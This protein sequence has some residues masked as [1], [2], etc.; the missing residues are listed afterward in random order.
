[1]LRP[2]SN[3][4]WCI[5]AQSTTNT[6][7]MDYHEFRFLSWKTATFKSA[8]FLY[9]ILTSLEHCLNSIIA[10]YFLSKIKLKILGSGF[11]FLHNFS[12][13]SDFIRRMILCWG[14]VIWWN[15][16]INSDS[17]RSDEVRTWIKC[18]CVR[19]WW[20]SFWS[21]LWEFDVWGWDIDILDMQT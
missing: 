11:M 10:I 5:R 20:H 6:P 21:V 15:S 14:I 19:P 13:T 7:S 12:W 4:Q 18:K 3:S 2:Q 16:R 8:S 1:M 17:D 9:M